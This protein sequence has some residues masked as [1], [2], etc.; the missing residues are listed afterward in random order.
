[1]S[2]FFFDSSA[3]VKRYVWEQGTGWVRS[4]CAPTAANS[5]LVSVI[6]PVEIIS[7]VSRRR[8]EGT[9]TPRAA[10]AVRLLLHRHLQREYRVIEL[11][12][13][14]L[15]RAQDLLEQQ[16]LRAYD[17]IQLA[18]A[19][20]ANARLLAGGLAPL[21]FVAADTRLLTIGTLVGLSGEDPTQ[22]L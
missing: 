9:V 5:L 19:L 7:A 11:A 12:A 22:H 20:E 6:M 14:I 17:A 3:L 10:Q 8:R 2:V 13:P 18:S 16:P 15:Q 21:I 4:L 1:M